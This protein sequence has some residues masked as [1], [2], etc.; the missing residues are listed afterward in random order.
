MKTL[1]CVS[2]GNFKYI[3][4]ELPLIKPGHSIIRIKRVGVCGTDLHAFE[5]TQPFFSYPRVLGHELA[6][7][8]V[9]GDAA[10]FERGELLTVLPY[11]NCGS[12]V[13]CRNHKPNCCTSIKVCGVHIDGG[14]TEFLLVPSS[15]LIKAEGLSLDQLA[16]VEPLAIGAHAISRAEVQAT[17]TVLVVGAGPIGIGIVEFARL[18][19]A[20]VILMDTNKDRLSFC[21]EWFKHIHLVNPLEIDPINRLRELTDGDMPSVVMDATGSLTAINN[22]F[23]YMA[24]GAR[25]VLVGLQLKDISFSH[26]EFH[27]REGTLL[28]SRNATKEDFALVIQAVKEGKVD[29]KKMITHRLPFG[30]VAERFSS[31]MDPDQKTIKALI[32]L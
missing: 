28:S 14:M 11:F 27:K 17:D 1:V 7:E 15:S 20:K 23:A 10:G 29:P 26:P 2:P 3:D 16:L 4:T 12:C 9:E 30:D 19:G 22:S 24:H 25:Y 32:E 6:A 21:K 8:F 18:R 5:G 13:A 31:L